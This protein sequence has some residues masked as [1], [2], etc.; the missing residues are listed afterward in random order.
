MPWLEPKE[1]PFTN[2]INY[3]YLY[4]FEGQK[5]F[6]VG[7]TF[8]G[9]QRHNEHLIRGPVFEFARKNNIKVPA[10]IILED[11]LD[12]I[13]DVREREDYWKLHY[14]SLGYNTLNRGKTGKFSG[15]LGGVP[16]KWTRKKCYELA[17]Q[18]SCAS[19]MC[20]KSHSA[21]TIVYRNGWRKDY[22]WWINDATKTPKPVLQY[23]KDGQLVKRWGSVYSAAKSLSRDHQGIR[24]CCIG[25]IKFA[26]GYV[27]KY[28]EP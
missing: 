18:C 5:T 2:R 28:E 7:E 21:Y 26:Y 15:S 4:L 25:K 13:N 22:T 19:E 3:I 6:Y 1:N 27:W 14:I 24:M 17:L 9:S 11:N 8:H 12:R 10:P 23:T 20:Q 16:I